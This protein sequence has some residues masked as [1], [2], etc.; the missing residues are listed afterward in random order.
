MGPGLG[1]SVD[2]RHTLRLCGED[3]IEAESAQAGEPGFQLPEACIPVSW[4]Q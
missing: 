3:H 4:K 2:W 1:S